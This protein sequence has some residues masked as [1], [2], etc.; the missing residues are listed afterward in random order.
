MNTNEQKTQMK[1]ILIVDLE[2]TCDDGIKNYPKEKREIIEIGAVVA[3]YEGKTYDE[4]S[5]F[6]K[7]VIIPT[8][9]D[10]CTELTSITQEQVD[11][12]LL[13]KDAFIIFND[14][15][16]KVVKMH[17]ELLGWGS[18]GYYDK[19]KF[20]Y[21]VKNLNRT[22]N[23]ELS[24]LNLKH[25]NIS[26]IYRIKNKLT[27]KAGLGKALSQQGLK[28]VG[29]PHRGIDDVKNIARLLPKTF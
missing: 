8:L 7:P 14:F 15:C 6:I 20:D 12:A 24:L 2:A 17:P 21:D 25:Y 1:K 9:S 22:E 26:D 11:D 13:M 28:F 19:G 3:D 29:T 5:I 4:F 18:W 23:F 16:S 10:F 27:R